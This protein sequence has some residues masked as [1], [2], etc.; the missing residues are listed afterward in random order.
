MKKIIMNFSAK[1]VLVM[2]AV[3]SFFF[4]AC[5]EKQEPTPVV[6]PVPAVYHIVGT[7]SNGATG[8]AIVNVTVTI[9]GASVPTNNGSFQYQVSG[10]GAYTI[11]AKADGFLDVT[12]T[13]QV[14]EV[15]DN[16]VSITSVDIA[17][18]DASSLPTNPV[19]PAG[20]SK[21]TAEQLGSLGFNDVDVIED[22]AFVTETA[23]EMEAT[24]AEV[25]VE[26]EINEGFIITGPATKAIDVYEYV[27]RS[28]SAALNK[29][30]YG[31]SFKKDKIKVTLGGNGNVLVGY[32][33]NRTYRMRDFV[34]EM[35]DG[36]KQ[37]FTAIYED[38]CEVVAQY[39]THDNH[40]N[41]GNGSTAVGGGKGD[42][43]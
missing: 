10:P 17:L 23:V 6:D 16:Q 1:Y 34:V 35:Y 9:N 19:E 13:V 24:D 30:Y 12:K 25:E 37:T 26:V 36:S 22:G 21:L 29:P 27:G 2:L 5:Y 43:A 32:Q 42:E 18:F 40:G 7:V 14:V 38:V 39:D 8:A 31:N 20:D 4:T 11:V 3:C 41:H 28:I 15:A 33:V